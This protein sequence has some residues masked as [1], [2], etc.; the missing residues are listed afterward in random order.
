MLAYIPEE[1]SPS[2]I[3]PSN[4]KINAI[5]VTTSAQWLQ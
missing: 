3:E 5:V 4:C 2:G 1:K